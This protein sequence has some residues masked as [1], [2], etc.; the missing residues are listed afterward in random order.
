VDARRW[1]GIGIGIG[2]DAGIVTCESLL[3]GMR[4]FLR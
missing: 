4:P 2:V 1:R 3:D